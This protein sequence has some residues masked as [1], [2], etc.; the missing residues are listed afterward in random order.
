MA[1]I[2]DFCRLPRAMCAWVHRLGWLALQFEGSLLPCDLLSLNLPPS[3]H[4]LAGESLCSPL[5]SLKSS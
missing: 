3:Q 4:A 2:S 5:R 1:V